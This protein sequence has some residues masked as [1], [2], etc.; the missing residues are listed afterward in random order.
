MLN[1]VRWPQRPCDTAWF[2]EFNIIQDK[3]G[4]VQSFELNYKSQNQET[5]CSIQQIVLCSPTQSF[6]VKNVNLGD[7][8]IRP[9][10]RLNRLTSEAVGPVSQEYN[11][12][13]FGRKIS[14][15][16]IQPSPDKREARLKKRAGIFH[17][18][19]TRADFSIFV[20]TFLEKYHQQPG[21][22]QPR[23][24]Y[25]QRICRLS[26]SEDVVE[27]QSEFGR[28]KANNARLP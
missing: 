17:M 18:T 7:V 24:P 9:A 14:F 12:F 20:V 23:L 2:V 1:R 15:I 28:G 10:A 27:K 13:F 8:Y 6:D 5:Y 22:K 21:W 25:E 11:L 16:W 26:N 3:L 19:L 4:H